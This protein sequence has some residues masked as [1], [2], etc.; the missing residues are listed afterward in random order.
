MKSN[1]LL[2]I[3]YLHF[4]SCGISP[5]TPQRFVISW[6]A[7]RKDLEFRRFIYKQTEQV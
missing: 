6:S 4:G 2:F 1:T 3:I 5:I 7:R